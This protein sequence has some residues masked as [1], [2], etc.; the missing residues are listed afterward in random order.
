M[1]WGQ[2]RLVAA[3]GPSSVAPQAGDLVQRPAWGGAGRR[4]AGEVPQEEAV[5]GEAGGCHSHGRQQAAG[6]RWQAGQSVQVRAS[7]PRKGAV[8]CLGCNAATTTP[9]PLLCADSLASYLSPPT[10]EIPS[11]MTVTLQGAIQ[12]CLTHFLGQ[13]AQDL[14]KKPVIF[15]GSLSEKALPQTMRNL[16]LQFLLPGPLSSPGVAVSCVLGTHWA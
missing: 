16:P 11:A 14:K 10:A 1:S 9:E 4:E 13:G 12:L 2:G 8:Y 3:A 5:S 7:Q 15:G 6:G